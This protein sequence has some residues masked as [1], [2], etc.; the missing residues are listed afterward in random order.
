MQQVGLANLETVLYTWS[1][2]QKEMRLLQVG[3]DHLLETIDKVAQRAQRFPFSDPQGQSIANIGLKSDPDETM[4][5]MP[6]FKE[7]KI[8]RIIP[9]PN[10]DQTLLFV[11][12]E[13]ML[14]WQLVNFALRITSQIPFD[15]AYIFNEHLSAYHC[16][17]FNY[18]PLYLDWGLPFQPLDEPVPLFVYAA[19]NEKAVPYLSDCNVESMRVSNQ[20]LEYL[21]L[22]KPIVQS[23]LDHQKYADLTIRAITVV[24]TQ[25][26]ESSSPLSWGGHAALII[27]G[28]KDGKSFILKIHLVKPKKKTEIRIELITPERLS[29]IVGKTETYLVDSKVVDQMITEIEKDR[30]F[31]E[32]S[33][34]EVIDYSLQGSRAASPR[35]V[36]G[37]FRSVESAEEHIRRELDPA[38]LKQHSVRPGSADTFEIVHRPDNCISYLLKKL[39]GVNIEIDIKQHAWISDYLIQLP[40][41]YIPPKK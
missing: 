12:K 38:D 9:T 6:S 37:G 41:M 21:Q 11:E 7:K 31:I 16:K 23:C 18:R 20:R 34:S 26:S 39:K 33:D 22:R 27:E 28:F 8:I 10:K 35:V 19:T 4:E 3:R 1:F 25:S 29:K 17:V 36:K 30:H 14:F 2:E 15:H 32:G 5:G 13:K 24:N 40:N